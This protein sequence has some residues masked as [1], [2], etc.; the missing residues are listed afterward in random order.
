M[1]ELPEYLKID[2]TNSI[3]KKEA[4][5]QGKYYRITVLSDLLLR[6]EYA[7]DSKFLDRPTELVINR[8]FDVPQMDVQEDEKFLVI[9]T[10]YFKLQYIKE[11][12]FQGSKIAP[13]ANLKVSLNNTGK[14][15][16]YNH[17]E[18]RNFNGSA[19]SLDDTEGNVKLEKGLYST[20]GFA[21]LD[22]SKTLVIDDEGGL[23]KRDAI[24][25]DIYLFMYKRDFGLCL[26]D[27]FHLTGNPP[28]LPRYALGIWWNKNQAY[29]FEDIKD[30]VN[31]FK[32]YQIP[33]SV[34]LLG[35][36]WHIK[37][38]KN[39][40]ELKTGFMFQAGGSMS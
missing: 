21:T 9:T 10:K 1:S 3:S 18:A 8:N 7:S 34:L 14:I 6:L 20:D 32:K 37:D 28:L 36:N 5:F 23:I 25:T 30:L 2:Q 39:P 16:Y 12:P 13:D 40:Q 31:L 33:L 24:R 15:W 35:E 27:Y 29:S 17:P 19:F 4:I 22:D 11:K 26:R 38:P